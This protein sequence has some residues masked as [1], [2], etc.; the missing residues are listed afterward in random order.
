MKKCSWGLLT[1]SISSVVGIF[2]QGKITSGLWI[3]RC[4]FRLEITLDLRIRLGGI[5][6]RYLGRL[7]YWKME[8]MESYWMIFQSIK[9]KIKNRLMRN[10]WKNSVIKF[11]KKFIRK[12]GKRM[13]MSFMKE[14]MFLILWGDW[15]LCLMKCHHLETLVYQ[16]SWSL[17]VSLIN[18]CLKKDLIYGLFHIINL[19]NGNRNRQK[20][21]LDQTEADELSDENTLLL[22]A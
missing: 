5:V 17:F 21:V 10:L 11:I 8:R 7:F 3:S 15:I 6:K 4:L 16:T 20:L 22:N 2:S 1:M 18:L 12:M 14:T 19:L 9:P 13:L